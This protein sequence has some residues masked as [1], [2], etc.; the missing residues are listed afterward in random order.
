MAKFI[1]PSNQNLL[2]LDKANILVIY[3][4]LYCFFNMNITFPLSIQ[5]SNRK[6]RSC[7]VSEVQCGLLLS[8]K[9]E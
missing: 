9:L 6:I 8:S 2:I 4:R 1:M 5:M 7:C 3:H